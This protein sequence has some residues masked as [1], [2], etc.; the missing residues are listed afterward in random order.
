MMQECFET[1]GMKGLKYHPDFGYSP[2]GSDSHKLLAIIEQHDGILLTHTGPL[3]PPSQCKY[4]DPRLLADIGVD[5]PNLKVVAAH[6]GYIDWRPWAAL[7]AHQPNLHGDLAMWDAFGFGRY[8]LFC[9]E[10]R[11]I[12]DFVGVEKILFGTDDP[13][14]KVVRSTRDWINIIKDLPENAPEGITFTKEETDA[15]LGGNAANILGLAKN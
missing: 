4:A 1:F 6:M 10:L 7:A 5:F 3:S 12:I 8:D 2:S 9:R 14:N 11:N 15:I 13:V